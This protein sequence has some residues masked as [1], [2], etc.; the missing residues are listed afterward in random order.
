MTCPGIRS[1]DL[2]AN[3]VP[4]IRQGLKNYRSGTYYEGFGWAEKE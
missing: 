3:M 1:S 4:C 2:P